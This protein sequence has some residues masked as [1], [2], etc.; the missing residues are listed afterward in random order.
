[1][2]VALDGKA[3]ALMADHSAVTH[4]PTLAKAVDNALIPEWACG[5]YQYAAA[6]GRGYG[7]TKPAKRNA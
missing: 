3:A 4:A 6:I 5:V 7:S 1:M 2:R